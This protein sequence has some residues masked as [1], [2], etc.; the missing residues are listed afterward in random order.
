[1]KRGALLLVL[2]A[3]CGAAA[4]RGQG[5]VEALRSTE[6]EIQ[7]LAADY[8]DRY[9][10]M[11]PEAA[12]SSGLADPRYDGSL[13]D[14][15][16]GSLRSWHARED[17]WLARLRAIDPRPLEGGPEWATYRMMREQLEVSV[18]KR[19]CREQLWGVKQM[20]GWQ[21]ALAMASAAQPVGSPGARQRLLARWKELPRLLAIEV[22]NLKEGLRLGFSAPKV[23][24]R[25]VI[26][27]MDALLKDPRS[28]YLFEPA[29]RDGDPE[30]KRAV[31][32]LLAQRI[33][34]ALKTYRG[35]LAAEYLPRAREAVAIE[36]HPDGKNCYAAYLREGNG[37]PLTAQQIH[38]LGLQQVERLSRE[39]GALGERAFGIGDAATVL[40]K[41]R[42]EPRY[43]FKDAQQ[44]LACSRAAVQHAKKFLPAAFG[45]L[46]RA[47]VVVR[48]QPPEH[49]T[50]A[51]TEYQ[52]AEVGRPG[53][54]WV[55]TAN[56]VRE[57]IS[58][59]ETTAF[60]EAIP[61]HHFQ[62]AV[63]LERGR[64]ISPV[65][66]HFWNVG[67]GEGW[68]LYAER[69]MSELGAFSSD[70]QR[71]GHLSD[72]LL[73]ASRLVVDTG[74]HAL[75]WSRQRGIQYL[76]AHTNSSAGGA[77]SEVDRYL[78]Y[79]GQA[80]G[81]MVGM[82]TI[83][84]LRDDARARLGRRFDLRQFNDRVLELG[85]VPLPVVDAHVRRWLDTVQNR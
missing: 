51:N 10:L 30:L 7:A 77:A 19:V 29:Q 70:L 64:E 54:F 48:P 83:L 22:T 35:F 8:V 67:F 40:A 2:L 76:L 60:H 17:A 58:S 13:T 57:S 37:M 59:C 4:G 80:T 28:T 12:R 25:L 41:V 73:R 38:Q 82:L 46:A 52:P 32:E 31:G 21:D 33:V 16:P 63:A 50:G 9:F 62:M 44:M 49:D 11:F 68:A 56:A 42:T 14:L 26:E 45:R 85:N 78:I 74:V 53:T 39:V 65:A 34:P 3:G 55:A 20:W 23:N 6:R 81:Y 5:R 69:L 27:Q 15:S 75:G 79:P 1:M 43:L 84:K 72:Q 36:A 47:D 61:G 71:I 66:K 24:V 18:A